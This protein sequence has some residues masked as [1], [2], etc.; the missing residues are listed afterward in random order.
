MTEV[1]RAVAELAAG[2]GTV[3]G[4]SFAG[5]LGSGYVFEMGIVATVAAARHASHVR[6]GVQGVSEGLDAAWATGVGPGVAAAKRV[7]VALQ[8]TDLQA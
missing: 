7:A 6:T 8:G 4:A 5:R 2:L 3:Q 1:W